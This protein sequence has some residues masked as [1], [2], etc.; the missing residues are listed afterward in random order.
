MNA[1][2]PHSVARISRVPSVL[3]DSAMSSFRAFRKVLNHLR[4]PL[5]QHGFE[6]FCLVANGHQDGNGRVESNFCPFIVLFDN[7]NFG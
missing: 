5:F 6:N 3:A 2:F 1:Y 4:D 7:H